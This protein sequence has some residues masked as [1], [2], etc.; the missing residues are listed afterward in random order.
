MKLIPKKTIL[1]VL[2]MHRSG[3]SVATR[4]FNLLGAGIGEDIMSPAEDNP[5]GFWEPTEIVAIH[6][7]L[8]QH[9]GC[10]W[11]DPRPLPSKWWEN[12]DIEEYII[13][14]RQLV[15]QYYSDIELPIIKD[16]RL[17]R[18]LPIWQKIFK[19]LQWEPRYILVGRSP[20][21]V[22]D[23]LFKR[24]G[25]ESRS[26]YLLWLRHLIEAE[27]W[28][29]G[30]KRTFLS[31]E[32]FFDDWEIRLKQCLIDLDL[33]TLHLSL[34]CKSDIDNFID[35][36]LRHN[37]V[38]ENAANSIPKL[39]LLVS[40]SFS[41]FQMVAF[42]HSSEEVLQKNL[43]EI[44]KL[45]SVV[46]SLYQSVWSHAMNEKNI[47]NDIMDPYWKIVELNSTVNEYDKQIT[48]L[49]EILFEHDKD[50]V[51]FIQTPGE[52]DG[53]MSK[54]HQVIVE[55]ERQ[56]SILNQTLSY[57]DEEITELSQTLSKNNIHLSE[58]S[59]TI[60]ERDAEI[61]TLADDNFRRG[62][63]ALGLE[64]QLKDAERKYAD[65]TSS[66]SWIITKP[67]RETRRW[68]NNP[69]FQLKRYIVGVAK[70]SRRVYTYLPFSHQTR[71][72][73][74]IYLTKYF[75]WLLRVSSSQPL[76]VPAL[77]LPKSQVKPKSDIDSIIGDINLNLATNSQPVV[78]VVIPVYGQ[79]EYTLRCLMSIALN[80]AS[81]PFEIIIVDDCSPDNSAEILQEVDGISLI[82]NEKNQGF[83]R[84]C[85]AGAKVASGQYL[86][87][88]N[89]DTEVIAGWLDELIRTFD[90]FPGTGL[91]G[92]KL[93]Y[94]DGSLQEA[95]GIIWKD[96]SAWNYGHNQDP[97]LPIFNYARE[98]DYC[99]GASIMLPKELFDELGGFDEHYLPAY[100]EDSD[101]AL[102]IRDRGY[103][104]I[105]QPLSVVVHYEGVTSG[106]DVTQGTKAYQVQNSIKLY[107]RWQKRL[108]HHQVNGQNVDQAK[109]RMAERRVLVL[110]HCTPTPNQ[111]A[112]SVTILNLM[113]LLREMGFQ[114]T[115]I[116]ENN[117]LYMPEYT[118]SLQR[119]G[120]EVLYAPYITSVEQHLKQC[121]NR[122]DLSFLFR[123]T[124]AEK[125]S[126]LIRK[127]CN[128]A[129]VLYHT[130]DLHFLRMSREAELH[131]NAVKK[132]V[133][134]EMKQRELA[135]IKAAD[136][137]IVHS[138]TELDL[139][140]E[141]L[142]Y[143]K[144][145]VFPLIMNIC[146]SVADYKT[147]RDIV[148][149][150]GY[151]HTPNVDAVKYFV[152]EIMPILRQRLKGVRFYAVG[153]KPPEEIKGLATDDII[154]TGFIENL[155][156]L[157]KQMRVS[158]APLRYGAGIKGKIG[159]AMTAGIPVVATS[160]AAEG[161]SLIDGENIL[162]ADGAE[163]YSEAVVRLYCNESLW[164]DM[165]KSGLSFAEH[166]WGAGAAW[167]TLNS[168]LSDIDL[169]C[170]KGNHALS[171]YSE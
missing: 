170:I 110:D 94:P 140:R 25:F 102:K 51:G 30:Y 78:T 12:S 90:E 54:I 46:D 49:Y 109:D 114:V 117:F 22:A 104:V 108:S 68:I 72:N 76:F 136:A 10:S 59:R 143:E 6:D 18:L 36:K 161:M 89:N 31:Y 87:F 45:L 139:L 118:T 58:L 111:D 84:S 8:L 91:V 101:L 119:V 39:S 1:V 162:I 121:G 16:P 156:P 64:K 112:G 171:L 80:P 157:L 151:Q 81:T 79:L 34:S 35:S 147:R 13:R 100:G 163:E 62:E 66:H 142:P 154:I 26:S 99:S 55:Y 134:D 122:Y 19:Q 37:I 38:T 148:F 86:Y 165:S 32:Q 88:L 33:T 63:W 166:S 75:P 159:T 135:A 74:N 43:D 125:Y 103:R 116:P 115:F 130:V 95:G 124:V 7:E 93:V 160:L 169:P 164:N 28:S 9:L 2:G 52:K 92:S 77:P 20:L 150:G 98:V 85:N 50:N 82:S 107:E 42:G 155:S 57:R 153:S 96:G 123:P 71:L 27:R 61:V 105:F 3:T 152:T 53:H 65:I 67:F 120:I 129:K 44:N 97:L 60:L 41:K 158:V 47:S 131:G 83:I 149:I 5:T 23:S 126:E 128:K 21:E 48:E 146:M 29:R 144:I 15:E 168:I 11:D 40:N 106:T 56:I 113:L 132:N 73:H 17:C 14:L 133:A 138:T 4:I 145:H 24:N 141:D 70:L 167:D 127:Y 69:V 137:S